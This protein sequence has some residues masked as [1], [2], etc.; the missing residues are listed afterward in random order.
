M[1]VLT[2]FN[3]GADDFISKPFSINE[4]TARVKAVLKRSETERKK[5]NEILKFGNIEFD[6]EKKR[7]LVDNTKIDLTKKEYEILLLLLENTGQV[8]SR[9]DILRRIWG[10]NIIVSERTV[11]REYN[12]YPEQIRQI[13][14]L[15]EKQD[16]VRIFF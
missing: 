4:L 14:L 3:L 1:T 15:P 16:R 13:W 12:P 10:G 5:N 9:E 11:D 7:V 2:G 6:N 8:L